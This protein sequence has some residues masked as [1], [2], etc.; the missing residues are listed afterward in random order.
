MI[1]GKLDRAA[2]ELQMKYRS[3]FGDEQG[4]EVLTDILRMLGLFDKATTLE[5]ATA[6]NVAVQI[7]EIMGIAHEKNAAL[8]VHALMQ[9]PPAPPKET[10]NE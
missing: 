5:E 10:D 2:N 8:V 4:Q 9:L 7:L 6:R 3:V 1:Y